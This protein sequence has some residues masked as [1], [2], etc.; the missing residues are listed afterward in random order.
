[1]EIKVNTG[2]VTYN[3]GGKV[4]VA[5]NPTDMA[6]G[7]RLLKAIDGLCELQEKPY[8]D[9]TKELLADMLKRDAEAREL[10]DELF[11]K[12]VCKPLYGTI[13]VFALADGLPLWANLL[14][15]IL[16]QMNEGSEKRMKEAEA[17]IAKYTKGY[18]L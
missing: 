1:M 4:E 16:K 7:D 5:F 8:P 3:L 11:E 15:A 13:S 2:L 12:E 18:E 10:I 14:T 9:D 6:F 17:R